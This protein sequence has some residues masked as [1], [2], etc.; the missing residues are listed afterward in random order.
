MPHP[1]HEDPT[2]QPLGTV[3]GPAIKHGIDRLHLDIDAADLPPEVHAIVTSPSKILPFSKQFQPHCQTQIQLFQPSI[4][5][6]LQ[7]DRLLTGKVQLLLSYAEVA[8]DY[9]PPQGADHWDA[10]VAVLAA[11]H[12]KY[13]QTFA[14]LGTEG[15]TV[16]FNER[17][18][19]HGQKNESVCALYADR[20][21]KVEPATAWPN[22][23]CV[24]L[25]MRLSGKADTERAGIITLDD[26]VHFVHRQFWRDRVVLLRPLK[27]V[28]VGQWLAA[29]DA[30]PKPDSTL[31]DEG[32]KWKSKNSLANAFCLH[33]GW[34]DPLMVGHLRNHK[35]YQSFEQLFRDLE[36]KARR[37]ARRDDSTSR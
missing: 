7:L 28:M 17:S 23:A 20:A 22:R 26:V 32:K 1:Q 21:S 25:E 24:H 36:S 2:N 15:T 34:L 29:A 19:K 33:N 31:S 5:T 37:K 8:M 30:K 18:N 16:Y 6:V 4:D 10:F 11:M 9:L 14:E 12:P 35:Q 13:C 3:K 27:N